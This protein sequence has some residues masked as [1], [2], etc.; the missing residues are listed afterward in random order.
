MAK[1]KI[2]LVKSK[3]GSDKTQVGT[4]Q[5]LGLK[6]TNSSVEKDGG[7]NQPSGSCGR[8]KISINILRT[9]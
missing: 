7:K 5:A 2:T 3:I 1:I 8:S 6:K 9:K 4:I